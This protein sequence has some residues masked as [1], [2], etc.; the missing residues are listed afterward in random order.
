MTRL[1]IGI[2]LVLFV[3]YGITE[4]WPLLRG[5]L[6]TI[7][8]PEN[9]ASYTNGIVTISGIALNT[10]SLTLDGADLIPTE[11]G[12]F[13]ST[14]TFPRGGTILTFVAVDRFGRRITK[15]REIFVP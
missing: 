5:P 9:G 1:L 8:S 4:G 10:S 3:G 15:T 7:T 11:H 2:V 14:L 6:I 13:S 12:S